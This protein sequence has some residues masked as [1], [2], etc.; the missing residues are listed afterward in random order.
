MQTSEVSI[1][2]NDCLEW[3]T[4]GSYYITYKLNQFIFNF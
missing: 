4:S 2:P 1:S 3:Y